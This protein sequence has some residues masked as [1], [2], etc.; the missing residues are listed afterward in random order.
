MNRDNREVQ[1][2][3]YHFRQCLE[4]EHGDNYPALQDLGLILKD[5]GD[6]NEALEEFIK[7]TQ[8][9]PPPMYYVH[10]AFEHAGST[11][12]EMGGNGDEEECELLEETSL[13]CFTLGLTLQC[14][15]LLCGKEASPSTLQPAFW[16][17]LSSLKK[18]LGQGRDFFQNV[19]KCGREEKLLLK[20][21]KNHF[22]TLPALKILAG[23]SDH[24]ADDVDS[25]MIKIR[26]LMTS[27]SYAEAMLLMS[28]KNLKLNPEGRAPLTKDEAKILLLA[29]QDRY[30]KSMPSEQVDDN[31]SSPANE[32]TIVARLNVA[33]SHVLFRQAFQ[34]AV[35]A[36]N[37]AAVKKTAQTVSSSAK[38]LDV[39]S[40][41]AKA[42]AASPKA[43]SPKGPGGSLMSPESAL[44]DDIPD[45][46]DKF[47]H[48][49]HVIFM[50]DSRDAEAESDASAMER[51]LRE[52]CGLKTS[53]MNASGEMPG[54]D[55]ERKEDASYVSG[56]VASAQL[57]VC[58][59]RGEEV[60]SEFA[61]LIQS[62]ITLD[63]SSR[64]DAVTAS[65]SSS[66]ASPPSASATAVTTSPPLFHVL[67][68]NSAPMPKVLRGHRLVSSWQFPPEVDRSRSRSNSSEVRAAVRLLGSLLDLQEEV[69]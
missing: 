7:I 30:L 35:S 8:I 45:V 13:F 15:S 54:S 68:L 11:L 4:I 21:L 3:I 19:K 62:V 66:P 52:V 39:S 26:D 10:Q 42:A 59:V 23:F 17:S 27:R 64:D 6:Y 67:L 53:R 69:E 14:L 22:R 51:L 28:L 37:N 43:Q 61:K 57:V 40:I 56:L 38:R 24:Q 16:F 49:L 25:V 36:M 2:A 65:T 44:L 5:V 29:A 63:T 32:G 18:A 1:Q 55:K 47:Y 41:S 48:N 12:R 31:E 34:E 58:V 60:S 9:W 46:D 50:H 20:S 33:A